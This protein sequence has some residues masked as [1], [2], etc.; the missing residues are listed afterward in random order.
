[1]ASASAVPAQ[2][3]EGDSPSLA[4]ALR[5][6]LPHGLCEGVALPAEWGPAAAAACALLP[7]ATG[8]HAVALRPRRRLTFVGGRIALLR[9]GARLGMPL[10]DLLPDEDGA[11]AL[12]VTAVGSVSHTPRVA[13]ALVDR[14]DGWSRGVD[15]ESLDPARV[16][17]APRVLVPAEL[18]AVGELPAAERWPAILLRFSV[19]E[20]I[21]KALRPFVRRLIGFAEAAV[22]P[23]ADGTCAVE[24]ALD[25][26]AGPFDLEARW[27]RLDRL[28][29]TTCRVRPHGEVV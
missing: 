12:P 4:T 18:R 7:P 17:I 1:M 26:R 14:A 15:L 13:V 10:G 5:L 24:L 11:P 6:D 9:A 8:A 21:Y 28:F 2:A 16:H 22:T 29:L 27:L 20:A 19:K 25:D 23:R 3:P